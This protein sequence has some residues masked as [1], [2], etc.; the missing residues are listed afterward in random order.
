AM[1]NFLRIER[2]LLLA[3]IAS[4]AQVNM[5]SRE[6]GETI[7]TNNP[8][9]LKNRCIN[10]LTPGLNDLPRLGSLVW[11]CS[12][13][14][15]VQKYLHFCQAA[16]DYDAAV[17]SPENTS[18][19]L[20]AIVQAQDSAA[21]TMFVYHLSAL[22]YEAWDFKHQQD[23]DRDPCVAKIYELVCYTY[24][25]KN[26]GGCTKGAQIPYL[27]P[28]KT[29]CEKYLEACQ[30]EC[31]D[32]SAQCVFEL[33][34][35]LGGGEVSK[36]TGYVDQK[37]P[38]AVCTGKSA[39]SRA[40]A[41][42]HLLLALFGLQLARLGS[43]ETPKASEAERHRGSKHWML[44]VALAGCAVSLQGC[45]LVV[46]THSKANWRRK[47]DYLIKYEH[48]PPGQPAAAAI[49]NSC[50]PGAAAR[51]VCSGH[52][53]CMPWSH[54]PL[55]LAAPG[56][57]AANLGVAFCQC[58]PGWADPECR[59]PRKSQLKAFFLSLFGGF[60]GLDRFYL[61]FPVS[62]LIKLVTLGGLGLWWLYD[63]VRVG[64]APVYA[65]DFRV[66]NDLPHWV[67]VLILVLL[68]GGGGIVYSLH[69]Y[70][71]YRK[72]KRAEA[73]KLLGQTSDRTH[74]RHSW[75]VTI[76]GTCCVKLA[77]YQEQ[78]KCYSLLAPFGSFL[79]RAHIFGG[80]VLCFSMLCEY[81]FDGFLA[82]PAFFW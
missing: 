74:S 46:P 10:P 79:R 39:S 6:D 7:Y 21:S 9:C 75:S 5:N 48:V 32:D 34:S 15:V 63:L 12:N 65:K 30:V 27:K 59:T 3:G 42:L 81:G 16:V 25:P 20:D 55:K 43:D 36:V 68:F 57:S 8:V 80:S 82:S 77:D 60:F 19:A 37:S 78:L 18:T 52:G 23:R 71:H 61:G 35:D 51:E 2:L 62:G 64:C 22:G 4:C 24:F 13:P 40:G 58:E 73:E 69:S 53:Q 28:C 44:F 56:E 47:P 17:P 29:P 70:V 1:N 50:T 31:C 41:P 49:L 11:Q 45:S 67:F 76:T 72:L 38:S 33:T 66:S 14:G 54:V 26:Q